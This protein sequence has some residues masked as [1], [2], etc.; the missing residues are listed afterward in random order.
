[1]LS[2]D[3]IDRIQHQFPDEASEFIAAIDA[4][5]TTSIRYNPRKYSEAIP[6][7]IPWCNEGCYLSE[8]PNFTLDPHF[9][10]GQYYVQESS[11]MFLDYMLQQ[12]KKRIDIDK[13]L[14]LCAAP[15]GKSTIVLNHLE[16]HQYL[17]AN[18]IIPNR[19]LILREN[20]SKWGFPNVLV[21]EN[22]PTD[23]Q[24]LKEFLDVIVLDAPCSGE[25]LFRK[26]KNA[27]SEWTVSVAEMC[28]QR[29]YEIFTSIWQN[30][31][32]GG[33]LIYST[34]TFNPEE[35]EKLLYQLQQDGFE[36][37]TFELKLPADWNIREVNYHNIKGFQF[38][39]HRTKGEGFFCSVLQKKG[40]WQ[41]TKS[42]SSKSY[43]NAWLADFIDTEALKNYST[44]KFKNSLYLAPNG[45]LDDL[46]ILNKQ[47]YVKQIGLEVGSYRGNEILPS[48]GLASLYID[49][50]NEWKL[51]LDKQESLAYL[52]G[53]TIG[54][55][56]KG[57]KLVCYEQSALGWINFSAKKQENLYPAAWRI[58]MREH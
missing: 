25:G 56:G 49:K 53:D 42:I 32:A 50:K 34:C 11:S 33:Y 41:K 9:H 54:V 15:G 51:F 31:K 52:R 8:R 43:I 47:L 17:I 35:N 36:F 40:E 4:E 29:Q 12:I 16:S 21:T 24:H 14:D 58:R 57:Y 30:L 19:N 27:R 5:P 28:S 1:M 37:E 55:T 10:S 3:F 23:F 48:Q 38:L 22:K 7:H 6:F 26:D 45:L 44:Y 20:I 39:P 2:L 18:E 13:V 46:P